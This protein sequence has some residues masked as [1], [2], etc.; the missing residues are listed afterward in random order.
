MSLFTFL[1]CEIM[2]VDDALTGQ[3]LTLL[4]LLPRVYFPGMKFPNKVQYYIQAKR[5]LMLDGVIF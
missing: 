5:F 3:R 1:T 4:V 2:K